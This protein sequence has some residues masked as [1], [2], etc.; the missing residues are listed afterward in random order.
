MTGTHES[1]SDS[2]AEFGILR[3][4]LTLGAFLLLW[5]L[6]KFL[7]PSATIRIAASFYG[8]GLPETVTP[9]IGIGELALSLS[10]L[11]GFAR[12]PVYGLAAIVHATSTMATWR[13]LLDPW[14]LDK[15]GNHLFIAGIPVLGAFIALYLLRTLDTYSVDG[16][17]NQRRQAAS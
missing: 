15:I 3:M 13:Q 2:Y 9:L 6:E 1:G 8:I 17:L 16:W 4:R 5:S 7:V 11:A 10:L 12:R 14:G